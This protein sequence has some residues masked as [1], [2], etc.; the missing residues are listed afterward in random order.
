MAASLGAAP[1]NADTS[2]QATVDSPANGPTVTVNN[3]GPTV[4]IDSP[5]DGATVAG[6][7]TIGATGSTDPNQSDAP[8]GI[9][10]A[11]DDHAHSSATCDG[12]SKTCHGVDHWNTLGLSGQH[13]ISVTMY[14]VNGDSATASITV[15]VKP[16]K[17]IQVQFP[18]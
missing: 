18:F 15:T 1:A 13:V 8:A 16:G 6:V 5:A 10:F 14:T 2:P 3:P 11:I 17:G 7:V 12:T 9:D 4:T